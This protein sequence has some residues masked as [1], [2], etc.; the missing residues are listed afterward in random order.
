MAAKAASRTRTRA[1][2]P[3][4]TPIRWDKVGRLALLAV[5][6]VIVLLYISPTIHYVEQRRTAAAHRQELARLE[7]EHARLK[8]RLDTLRRPESLEREAR[9]LGMVKLGERAFVIEGLPPS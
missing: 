8:G 2:A 3:A 9:K 1:P 4:R 5:L 6:G 7:Q